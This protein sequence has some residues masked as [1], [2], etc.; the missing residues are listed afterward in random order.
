MANDWKDRLGVVYSTNPDFEFGKSVTLIT[1]FVG[2]EED[3][4]I[5]GKLLKTKCGVGGTVKDGEIL[6]Q[7]DFRQKVV[8]ILQDNKYKAKII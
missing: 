6:I 2:T 4:K 5:L 1:G 7:G 8:D 3:L